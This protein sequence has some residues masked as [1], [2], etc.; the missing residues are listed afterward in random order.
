MIL[1][2]TSAQKVKVHNA[3]I[4]AITQ[5]LNDTLQGIHADK[6]LLS[7]FKTH[8]RYGKRDRSFIADHFYHIIRYLRYLQYIAQYNQLNEKESKT[9]VR[10]YFSLSPQFLYTHKISYLQYPAP[11]KIPPAI[12]LSYPDWL[13]ETI[14]KDYGEHGILQMEALNTRAPLV[15]RLCGQNS[16]SGMHQYLQKKEI[17][18]ETH[19]EVKGAIILKENTNV[20]SWEIFRQGWFEVQDINSQK[21]SLYACPQDG[22]VVIDACAGAGGKTLHLA[23]LMHNKGKII[24]MDIDYKKLNELKRRAARHHLTNIEVRPIRNNKTIKRLK[25]KA[26]ILLLDVPCSGTGVIRRNPDTKWKLTPAHL[27]KLVQTQQYLLQH[28]STM[29]K[30]GGKLVY[31]TCSILKDENQQQVK[32]FLQQNPHFELM[33]EHNL[34]PHETGFDGFYVALLRRKKTSAATS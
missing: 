25:E 21:V 13:F 28:Y 31:A 34:L 15:L 32:L 2:N 3:W 20:F 26:D 29:V 8:S 24:A 18:Y 12:A 19:P 5:A 11:E 6:A 1:K 16:L 23:D 17:E 9:L 7:L 30:P 33:E 14:I 27:Q 4:E 22:Q 10:I